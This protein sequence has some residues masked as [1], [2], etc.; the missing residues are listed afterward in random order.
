MSTDKK[1]EEMN[2]V[3]MYL[4]ILLPLECFLHI[5]LIIFLLVI[6]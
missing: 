5:L 2:I 1:N 3:F 6:F 4:L